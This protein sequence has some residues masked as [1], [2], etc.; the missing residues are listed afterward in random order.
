MITAR[1]LHCNYNVAC[2]GE[3]CWILNL[4]WFRWIALSVNKYFNIISLTSWSLFFLSRGVLCMLRG[5]KTPSI[6]WHIDPSSCCADWALTLKIILSNEVQSAA[7]L[8]CFFFFVFFWGIDAAVAS[9][10]RVTFGFIL[11]QLIT[12]FLHPVGLRFHKHHQTTDVSLDSL[13]NK[14][15]LYSTL[16][17]PPMFALVLHSCS[18]SYYHP[19]E[20]QQHQEVNRNRKRLGSPWSKQVWNEEGE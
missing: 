17:I 5:K 8:L 11:W 19:K 14:Y 20:T 7:G 12:F 10:S 18:K 16:T 13:W 2:D 3:Y 9:K 4:I 1:L 15:I 6:Y